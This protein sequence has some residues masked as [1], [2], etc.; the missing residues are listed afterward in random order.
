MMVVKYQLT[1]VPGLYEVNIHK[2]AQILHFAIQN[3]T[4]TIW[5][6]VNADA[7]IIAA[8]F[9]LAFTGFELKTKGVVTYIGTAIKTENNLVYHLF[10]HGQ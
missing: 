5:A 10:R 4:P 1:T 7:R 6:L 3:G 2:D 9:E 8:K